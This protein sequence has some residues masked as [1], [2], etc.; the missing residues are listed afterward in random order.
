MYTRT[1]AVT[2]RER[3]GMPIYKALKGWDEF[4]VGT[5]S[6]NS[7]GYKPAYSIN[8]TLLVYDAIGAITNTISFENFFI[9]ELADIQLDGQSSQGMEI[10][11]TFSFDRM[12]SGGVV[13]L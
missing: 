5:E 6:G 1:L 10:S 13:I 12:V 4:I 7:G 11:A 3:A 9:Q 2:F 8:P